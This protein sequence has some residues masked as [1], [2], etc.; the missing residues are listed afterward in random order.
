[1]AI[2]ATLV[3]SRPNHLRYLIVA[4]A[5]SGEAVA[6]P[7]ATLLAATQ[8]GPLKNIM[9]VKTQGYGKLPAG[10]TITQALAR[11]LL[12]SD[13]AVADVGNNVPTAFCTLTQRTGTGS[14]IVD[15]DVDGGDSQ[16]PELNVAAVAAGAASAYLDV[17]I[18][19]AIGF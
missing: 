4:S 3:A 12:M 13:D 5:G 10:G 16:L 2:T 15:A 19:G 7:G 14:V 9:N 17:Y 6:I 11:S 8:A 18:P 1:M